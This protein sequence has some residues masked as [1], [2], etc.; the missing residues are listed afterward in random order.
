LWLEDLIYVYLFGALGVV[1][2]IKR[3]LYYL[4]C[5]TRVFFLATLFVAHRDLSRYSLPLAPFALIAFAP[6]LEKKEFKIAFF[7]I[8]IPIYLY[9]I[10]FILHNTAPI[11]DWTP[12]L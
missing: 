10:N 9:T 12:Y 4:A 6:Y 8:L 2:L 5:F 7:F 11:A 1:L 3:K